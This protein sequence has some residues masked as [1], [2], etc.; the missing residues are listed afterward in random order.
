MFVIINEEGGKFLYNGK[1][2]CEYG[3]VIEIREE[4]WLFFFFLLVWFVLFVFF[5]I[6][7]LGIIYD[8]VIIIIVLGNLGY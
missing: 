4:F 8:F 5:Y 6:I 1:G 7:D 3:G 2:F